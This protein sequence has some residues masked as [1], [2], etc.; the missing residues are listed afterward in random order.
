M[1]KIILTIL[2]TVFFSSP[3]IAENLAEGTWGKSKSG[4]KEAW[5]GIKEGSENAW[6]GVKQGS[7]NAWEGTEET[8]KEIKTESKGIWQSIKDVFK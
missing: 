2:L 6:S 4:M 5:G 8:R 1:Y 7:K 3:V